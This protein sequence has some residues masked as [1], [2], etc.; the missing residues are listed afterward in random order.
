MG[1]GEQELEANDKDQSLLDL[2]KALDD[3]GRQKDAERTG[4]GTGGKP[5]SKRATRPGA[6]DDSVSDQEGD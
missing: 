4:D 1:S 2:R 6:G 5:D 3:R